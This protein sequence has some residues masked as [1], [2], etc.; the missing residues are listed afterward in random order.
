MPGA[1][2]RG[3]PRDHAYALLAVG[4]FTTLLA[5]FAI[6]GALRVPLLIDPTSTLHGT[7][8]LAGVLSVALLTAD[9][10]VPLPSS[11]VMT[12]NGALFGIAVGA[13]LSLLGGIGATVAGVAIGR[14]SR[15][16]VDRLASTGQQERADR[17]LARYGVVAVVV[18]RP[19]PLLAETTAIMAGAAGLSWRRTTLAGAAGNV[20]PATVY[21]IAGAATA[22]MAS[23]VLVFGGVMLVALT[24]WLVATRRGAIRTSR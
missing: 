18:T 14:H 7:G 19:V 9:V 16:W 6:V 11:V 21:A 24:V 13:L 12:V 22:G 2:S 17:L 10:V 20:V 15:R 8:A 3:W 1:P 4:I 23:T 5:A